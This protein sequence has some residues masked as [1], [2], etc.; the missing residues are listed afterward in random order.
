MFCSSDA[1]VFEYVIMPW[2]ALAVVLVQ[3]QASLQNPVAVVQ[4]DPEIF[5]QDT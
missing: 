3:D 4:P 1:G 2:W 5:F